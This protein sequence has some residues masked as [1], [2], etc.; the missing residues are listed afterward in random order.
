MAIDAILH[1]NALYLL[2]KLVQ[3]TAHP[4]GV[5]RGQIIRPHSKTKA[6]KGKQ[7]AS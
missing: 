7:Q 5:I 1:Q 6:K 3:P 2:V 4:L